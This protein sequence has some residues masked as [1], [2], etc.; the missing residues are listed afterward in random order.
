MKIAFLSTFALDA[1]LS[2]MHALEKRAEVF[3]FTEA[4]YR[5]FNFLD[6]EKLTKVITRGDEVEELAKFNDFVN[7][8]KTFV[9]KGIR[10]ADIFK[11]LK[12]SWLIHKK[13]LVLKPDVIIIDNYM[14][15]YL[16]SALIFRKKALMVVHDPFLHS[17]ENHFLD[18]LLRSFFFR[19]IKNK[20]LLNEQQRDAFIDHYRFSKNDIFTSFLSVY[21]FLRFFES[22]KKKNTS[23]FKILFFGRISPYKG[24]KFLL[25]GYKKALNINSDLILTI[26]GSGDFDFDFYDYK[27]LK[28]LTIENRYIEPSELAQFI[29]DTDVVICPYTDAT[30]S[31]VIMSSF[32]MKKPVIATNV[33]GLGEMI[34]DNITGILIKPSD[35]DAVA[36]AVLHLANNKN[37]L[38]VMSENIKK[39]YFEGD[40]SWDVSAAHFYEAC[41]KIKIL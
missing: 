39:K 1:N 3:F 9:V 34:D 37:L 24:L 12:I 11:K 38:S 33:G 32:A 25:E 13:L 10:N 17:G 14:L 41:K 2:L 20:V 26:A 15:T 23:S 35:A 31:G 21:D 29:S 7:L 27:N 16:F 28:G 30:Q 18:R 5:K 36:D 40:K 4:L 22:S 19:L 8:K 6:K